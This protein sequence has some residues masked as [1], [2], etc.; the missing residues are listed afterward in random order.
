M[1]PQT[2]NIQN[3]INNAYSSTDMLIESFDP[4]NGQLLCVMPDSGENEAHM[5]VRAARQAFGSWSQ[6][7]VE[8]RAEF[9]NKI[10]K[11]QTTELDIS[12]QIF[13]LTTFSQ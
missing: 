4:S 6:E 3:F 1:A 5:A 9:L 11:S 12:L 7:S 13:R 2:V 10:G 8:V